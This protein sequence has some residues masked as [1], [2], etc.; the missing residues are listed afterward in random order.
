MISSPDVSSSSSGT[1]FIN[2]TRFEGVF[3]SVPSNAESL[4]FKADLLGDFETERE[5]EEFS[6]RGFEGVGFAEDAG[7]WFL[8]RACR[9]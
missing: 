6:S 3:C 7:V 1:D 2:A 4:R 5:T 8:R 9:S